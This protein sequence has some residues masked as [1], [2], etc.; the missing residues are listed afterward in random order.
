MPINNTPMEQVKEYLALCKEFEK[1]RLANK[2]TKKM[3]PILFTTE[4]V[5][6]I[7]KGNK[8]QTR[9]IFKEKGSKILKDDLLYVRETF[10]KDGD[11]IIY[12]AGVCSKWDLPDGCKW[13]P[14]LFMPKDIARIFLNVVQVHTEM[15]H[16][17][18]EADCLKEGIIQASRT[19]YF[20][21]KRREISFDTAKEAFQDLWEQINGKGSWALN[22]KLNVISFQIKGIND[23]K[24]LGL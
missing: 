16:D 22:P 24:T 18:S 17:I 7:L 4:M 21:P 9:R 3:K 12:R 14:S 23:I 1:K 10:S 11:K 15:L 5:Q 20:N 2:S 6:A 8:T 13:K 19:V